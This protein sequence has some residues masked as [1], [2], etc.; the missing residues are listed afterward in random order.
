MIRSIAAA[1]LLISVAA[2]TPPAQ[3]D[4][5]PMPIEGAPQAAEAP[6]DVLAVIS[7][8]DATFMPT[9]SIEDNTTGA[10]TF[11]VKGTAA[12]G[13]ITT[14][15]VMHFN[16][17]WR[18]VQISRDVRWA[19]APQAVRDAVATSPQAIVPDRVV[20]VHGQGAAGEGVVMYDLYAAGASDPAVSVR[21]ADGEAAIMPAPH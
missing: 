9:E 18:I 15:N 19:D 6:A 10:R 11:K 16:E 14:Y 13:Q 2:C 21:V 8:A 20:E 5:T 17:G 7:A 12:N 4:E 1:A 3:Q